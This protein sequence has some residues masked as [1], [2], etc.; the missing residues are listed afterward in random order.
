[1]KLCGAGYD[2][3]VVGLSACHY[4]KTKS[5]GAYTDLNNEL[6]CWAIKEKKRRIGKRLFYNWYR[7]NIL[8]HRC[9]LWIYWHILW[10][11]YE[12]STCSYISFSNEIPSFDDMP[13]IKQEFE[14]CL[15]EFKAQMNFLIIKKNSQ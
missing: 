14:K 11:M 9:L 7:K 3:E 12:T 4:H 8:S 15:D 13:P 1:M 2:S 10:R 5:H 6:T